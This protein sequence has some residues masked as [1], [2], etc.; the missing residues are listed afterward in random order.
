MPTYENKLIKEIAELQSN[1][2]STTEKLIKDV[3]RQDR[4]MVRSDKRQKEDYD[5]LQLRL[6]EVEKLQ[7]AQKDLL[8]SF[9][10]ILAH[11]IDTKSKYTGGHCERVPKLSLMIADAASQSNEEIFQEFQL[12]TED[13]RREISIASWL[14]DCGKVT[15][16]EYV[17]DK[18]TKLETIYNRIHE[19]RTRFEVIHR[20]K[21]IE[22][23]NKKLSGEDPLL[24]EKWE[25]QEHEKLQKDFELV[26][27]ANLGS[28]FMT[29]KAKESILQI[30][31]YT[32]VRNFDDTIGLSNEEKTRILQQ[33]SVFPQTEKLLDDKLNHIIKRE[34]FDYEQYEK[35]EF[36]TK[37]PENLYNLGELYNLTIKAGTLNYEERFKIQEHAQVTIMMLEQLPFPKYL[38]NVPLYAG[39]HHETLIGTGY[40]RQLTKEQLP[41]PSRILA[42]ADIFESLTATDRPY[43]E[44]KILSETIKIM[45]TMAQK[46]HID[47]DIFKLFLSSGIYLDYSKKY[48]N[49][50]QIDFVD[51]TKYI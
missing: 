25:K 30:A 29:E 50:D 1:F 21:T 20:D 33:N 45:N 12:T 41:I 9:I 22:A 47:L 4:I 3:K 5:N 39:A 51:V 17:V 6:L 31:K 28:E 23:L 24:V 44:P 8:D 35:M 46:Q 16:P 42:I 43:K 19:I 2:H 7:E 48:L 18:A 26:A 10:K 11:A 37:V 15:T 49:K 27:Q 40:P 36:K 13:Q 14:H 32:W 38:S 34:N